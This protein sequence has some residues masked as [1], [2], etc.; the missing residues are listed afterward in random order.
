[1]STYLLMVSIVHDTKRVGV[2]SIP[3][4]HLRRVTLLG[5]KNLCAPEKLGKVPMT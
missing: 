1:M 2:L 3:P 5:M 4:K